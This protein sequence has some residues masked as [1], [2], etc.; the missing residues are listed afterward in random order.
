ML[1]HLTALVLLPAMALAGVTFETDA[2]PVNRAAPG[3]SY[4]DMLARITPAVVSVRTAEVIPDRWP[5]MAEMEAVPVIVN[6][7]DARSSE[8]FAEPS[9]SAAVRKSVFESLT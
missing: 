9:V 5:L 3:A 4:A 2:R 8:T 7:A 6:G 1:R